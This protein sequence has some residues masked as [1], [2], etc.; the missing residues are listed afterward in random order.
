MKTYQE[1]KDK[2]QAEFSAFEGIF[3]AFTNSQAKEGMEKLGLNADLQNDRDKV[4]A[5]GSGMFCLKSRV[6][7]LNALF[8]RLEKRKEDALKDECFLLGALECELSNHEF[9]VTGRVSDALDAL[10]LT[11]EDVP[12]WVINE[13]CTR[14]LE[15]CEI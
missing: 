9:C 10:N 14:S 2:N 13:A 5:M 4:A 3:F 6:S 11:R 7:E 12:G 8:D 1:L 15:S